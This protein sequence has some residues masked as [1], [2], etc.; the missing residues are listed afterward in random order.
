MTKEIAMAKSIEDAQREN[1][2]LQQQH[3]E[4]R[5]ARQQKGEDP[6]DTGAF[7]QHEQAIGAPDPG[8]AMGAGQST[9]PQ[10]QGGPSQGAG[11]VKDQVA[12]GVQEAV[13]RATGKGQ[14]QT[15]GQGDRP[16]KGGGLQDQIA[17]TLKEAVGRA[18]GS[19]QSQAEGQEQREGGR[20]S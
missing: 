14:S 5:Q 20:T 3:D 10:P 16:Q 4:W 17:G 13:G 15:E 12:Q 18:T 19:Q 8:E 1:P 11:N 9:S 6:N 7:R 2:N